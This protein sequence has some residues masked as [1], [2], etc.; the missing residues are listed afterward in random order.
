VHT[1]ESGSENSLM[2]GI[3]N[4]V[5]NCRAVTSIWNAKKCKDDACSSGDSPIR[6]ICAVPARLAFDVSGSG[7]QMAAHESLRTTALYDRRDD[8]VAVDEVERILI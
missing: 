1:L 2:R 6:P 5:L 4:A 3:S 7:T 8:Q